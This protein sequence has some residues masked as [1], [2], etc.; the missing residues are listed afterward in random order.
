MGN[1]PFNNPGLH[2]RAPNSDRGELLLY[3]KPYSGGISMLDS[4]LRFMR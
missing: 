3:Q 2:G 1:D 4:L